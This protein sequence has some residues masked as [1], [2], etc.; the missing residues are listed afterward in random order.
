MN[1]VLLVDI[2]SSREAGQGKVRNMLDG[3]VQGPGV[4]I[5]ILIG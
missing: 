1:E 5:K 2:G 3:K 4:R